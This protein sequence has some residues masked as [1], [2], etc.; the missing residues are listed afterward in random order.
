[1]D[2]FLKNVNMVAKET[3]MLNADMRGKHSRKF[4]KYHHS[5]SL[6]YPLHVYVFNQ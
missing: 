1:M 2:F 5:V 4:Q 6:I 3:A